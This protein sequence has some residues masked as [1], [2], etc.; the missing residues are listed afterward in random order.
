MCGVGAEIAKNI[1]L[2][3]VASLTIVDDR[4]VSD[5]LRAANFF[6][7]ENDDETKNVLLFL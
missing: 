6:L 2:T 3:G 7:S 1:M 4:N 5:E